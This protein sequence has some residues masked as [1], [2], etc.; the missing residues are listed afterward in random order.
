MLSLSG[1]YRPILPIAMITG[2]LALFPFSALMAQPSES[3]SRIHPLYSV[4]SPET[5]QTHP[6]NGV[7]SIN[8]HSDTGQ[9]I[10]CPEFQQQIGRPRTISLTGENSQRK[11]SAGADEPTTSEDSR[12]R[13][14][15]VE[16]SKHAVTRCNGSSYATT[17]V[18]YPEDDLWDVV[19]SYIDT[20][21]SQF[22][23]RHWV[24]FDSQEVT[25]WEWDGEHS[26]GVL[27]VL[28]Q[29]SQYATTADLYFYYSEK[30]TD[31]PI[32][33]R[34]GLCAM[35]GSNPAQLNVSGRNAID[36]RQDFGLESNGHAGRSHLALTFSV[37]LIIQHTKVPK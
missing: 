15:T 32:S 6:L 12:D 26:R 30:E 10:I 13:S 29:N 1:L 28:P 35:P 33:P 2:S 4:Y 20:N 19:H 24:H 7:V 5:G 23:N 11:R 14:P 34:I 16:Q 36:Q 17:V 22:S 37:W 21:G 8:C 3:G 31:L 9:Q 18:I 27:F 25:P